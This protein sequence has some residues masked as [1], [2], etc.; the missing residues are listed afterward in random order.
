MLFYAVAVFASFLMGLLAMAR[1]SWQ[2]RNIRLLVV[3]CF[4]ATAVAFTL[5]INLARG[6]PLLSFGAVVVIA[7]GL[8]ALWV[9][10]G[11]PAGLEELE[12]HIDD[13]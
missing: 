3:N 7:I 13:Q 11:R 8:H 5:A 9:R 6:Y 1:F 12:R 10:A 4:A 2:E